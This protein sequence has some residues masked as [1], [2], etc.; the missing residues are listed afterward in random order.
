MRI[1]VFSDTHGRL[2][3]LPEARAHTGPVDVILHLGD[4]CRDAGE[5]SRVFGAPCLAVR[6][7]CD[8]C[9][10]E[11]L[12]RILE[13]DGVRLLCIH[14]HLVPDLDA[15]SYKAEQERCSAALIGHTHMQLVERRGNVL[16]VN[17]GS[18][19]RPRGGSAQGCAVLMIRQGEIQ[20]QLISL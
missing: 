20:A 11:P 5:V 18:L 9:V 17:P 8:F 6:G 14:G 16:L 19:A 15:L 13:F 12:M 2:D 3:L 4:Y 1:A 10:D 7:N